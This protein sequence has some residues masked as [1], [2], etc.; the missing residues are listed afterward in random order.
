MKNLVVAILAFAF[1]GYCFYYHNG[2]KLFSDPPPGRASAAAAA[3]PE[4]TTIKDVNGRSWTC[5]VKSGTYR[6]TPKPL[7]KPSLVHDGRLIR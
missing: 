4:P 2:Q 7:P 5:T 3:A 6:C 1:V